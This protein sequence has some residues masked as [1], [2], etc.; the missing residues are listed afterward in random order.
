MRNK[1]S[2]KAKR[3]EV[4][5]KKNSGPPTREMFSFLRSRAM[6]KMSILSRIGSVIPCVYVHKS[7]FVHAKIAINF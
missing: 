6:G 3:E 7:K 5:E 2:R 1:G 4:V